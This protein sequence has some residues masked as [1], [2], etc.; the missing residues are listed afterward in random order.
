M[1]GPLSAGARYGSTDGSTLI[2][3]ALPGA[4]LK[5]GILGG[6]APGERVRGGRVGRRT[7]VTRLT[8]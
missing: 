3:V 2:Q 7:L 1:I 5:I 4:C 6:S 8:R